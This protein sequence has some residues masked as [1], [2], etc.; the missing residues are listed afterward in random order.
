MGM[1]QFHWNHLDQRGKIHKVGLLHG[2]RTGHV[3]IH[4]NGKITSIDFK[5]LESKQYSLFIDEELIELNIIRHDDHFEYTM[6]I[7]E[8]VKTP[9]NAARK[10]ER[11]K[12]GMQTLV[13]LAALVLAI[14]IATVFLFRSDWYNAKDNVAMAELEKRGLFTKA[15]IFTF[16]NNKFTYNYV[17][18]QQV[19]RI[20]S[21]NKQYPVQ[22]GDEYM[23]KYLPNNPQISEL[24]FVKPTKNQI[25][26][27]QKRSTNACLKDPKNAFDC[28]CL[29]EVVYETGGY[30]GMI[31]YLHRET[32]QS[33]NL[34]FN[35][36]AYEKLVNSDS[37]V[38]TLSAKC[39]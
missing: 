11:K 28:D 9:L 20:H 2:A 39:K 27:V 3:L 18:N 33:K 22:D 7:N 35:T 4:V 31:Q 14:I 15:K 25:V 8:E 12:M 16:G 34:Q 24:H 6:E 21:G 38:S 36:K 19:F 29:V 1:K 5:V 30:M 17:V 13:F 37:Y 10:K 26:K 23:V 32:P